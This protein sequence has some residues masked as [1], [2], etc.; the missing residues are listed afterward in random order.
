MTRLEF[1]YH[2]DIIARYPSVCGGI[3]LSEDIHNGPTPQ[4]LQQAFLGE[5]QE[6]LA[7]IGETPLSEIPSLAAWR[8]AFR[9]FGVDPTKYRSAAE[10]LL[11][12]LTKKGDIPCINRLVDI[13]NLVSIRYAL[14]VAAFDANIINGA[15]TVLFAQGTESFLAHDSTSPEIPEEGEVIFMD[16]SRLVI[17][18]RWCWKQS[19]E[20]TASLDTNT[21]I[22]TIESQHEMGQEE[23]RNALND[24]LDL[25]RKYLGGSYVSGIIRLDHPVI[26]NQG[27]EQETPDIA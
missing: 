14:P 2:P 1:R 12:R 13:C 23:I 10:A 18:R 21:A 16:E 20:S 5:Q 25:L 3:I 15:V 11:R 17:A 9:A 22:L 24:L 8:T 4:E 7:R 26:S 27:D 6:V 19:V